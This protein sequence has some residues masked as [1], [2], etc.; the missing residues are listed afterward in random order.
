EADV[1]L[2]NGRLLVGH[3]ADKLEPGR[4]LESLY[5]D[6]LLKRIEANGG[7]LFAVGPPA[8][9]LIDVKSEA[10]STYRELREILKKYTAILT[11][12]ENGKVFTNALTVIVSGNRAKEMMASEPVRSAGMAG[13]TA[14]LDWAESPA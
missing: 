4:T 11:R 7:R 14:A 1:F 12:F 3:D 5:L 9:L 8:T 10:A 6:P 2:V 13:R